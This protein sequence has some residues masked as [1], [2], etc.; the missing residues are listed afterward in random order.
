[1]WILLAAV[2]CAAGPRVA[3]DGN[4]HGSPDGGVSDDA[5]R[6][7]R[8]ARADLAKRL[9]IEE[10]KVKKRSIEPR[11]WPDASLGCPKPDTMYAQVE[12]PGYVIEL[13]ASG[14][15]YAYHCDYRRVV[16]CE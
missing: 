14:K 10:R 9:G 1:M 15:K 5:D 7:Y 11:T 3:L 6:V 2:L 4:P 13:E 8:M 12:T 16:L